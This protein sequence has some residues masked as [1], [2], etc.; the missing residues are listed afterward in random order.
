MQIKNAYYQKPQANQVSFEVQKEEPII[1]VI[2]Q[3]DQ[4]RNNLKVKS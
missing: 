3:R 4:A 1:Q 2:Q